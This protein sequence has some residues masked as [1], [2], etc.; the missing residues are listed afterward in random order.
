VLMSYPL[1]TVA[2]DGVGEGIGLA[3]GLGLTTGVGL[4]DGLIDAVGEG[5]GEGV[6]PTALA[7]IGKKDVSKRLEIIRRN[8]QLPGLGLLIGLSLTFPLEN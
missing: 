5:L 2:V 1:I 4:G 8:F 6:S 3:D 7:E